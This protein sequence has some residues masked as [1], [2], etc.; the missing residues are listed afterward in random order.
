MP[1]LCQLRDPCLSFNSNFC[2][3]VPSNDLVARLNRYFK[4][5]LM[6]QHALPSL[7]PLPDSL[8]PST[9]C[10]S[11]KIARRTSTWYRIFGAN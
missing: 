5:D 10:H 6:S 7:G 1:K 8:A 11:E 3:Y 9:E 4:D 2:D